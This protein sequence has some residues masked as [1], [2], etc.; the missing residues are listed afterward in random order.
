MSD[1]TFFERMG[2]IPTYH[3]T[4]AR[5]IKS[6][7]AKGLLPMPMT[8][9][10]ILTN[11]RVLSWKLKN[12]KYIWVWQNEQTPKSNTGNLILK[13]VNF[14]ATKVA[15][16][17]VWV[18]RKEINCW[19]NSSSMTGNH[20]GFL[21]KSDDKGRWVFHRDEPSYLLRYRVPP[22]RIEVVKIYDIIKL[23]K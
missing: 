9:E 19:P 23:L 10:E 1:K 15:L 4:P 21:T 18:T 13:M 2:L 3:Y 14:D 12:M 5:N 20:L 8:K 17:R 16:L 11:P 22:K 6:I 7:M